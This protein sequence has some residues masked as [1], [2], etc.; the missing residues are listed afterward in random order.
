MN[1]VC[2][3][4]ARPIPRLTGAAQLPA[5][6]IGEGM[7]T[8]RRDA[9]IDRA[10]VSTT[11]LFLKIVLDSMHGQPH[12]RASRRRGHDQQRQPQLSRAHGH[13][14]RRDLPGVASGRRS[15][16]CRWRDRRPARGGA[17][18]SGDQATLINQVEAHRTPHN[19]TVPS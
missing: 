2:R 18:V 5:Q 16:R 17:G 7:P 1:E 8:A 6:P 9:R 14:R 19:L 11:R 10:L 4:A 15:Q 12:E 13:P 3:Q